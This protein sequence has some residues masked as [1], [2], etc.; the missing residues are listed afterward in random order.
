MENAL[1]LGERYRTLTPAIPLTTGDSVSPMA[2]NVVTTA[3][4]HASFPIIA[5]PTLPMV[6]STHP[7]LTPS[8]PVHPA[9]VNTA[10]GNPV[11]KELCWVRRLSN[12]WSDRKLNMR[13]CNGYGD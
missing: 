2:S 12:E 5:V 7:L 4:P 6:A 11:D 8:I 13:N 3:A 10:A 9:V 1:C